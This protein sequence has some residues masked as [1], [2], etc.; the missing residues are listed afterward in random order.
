ML[1]VLVVLLQKIH[2]ESRAVEEAVLVVNLERV[3]RRHVQRTLVADLGGDEFGQFDRRMLGE[4]E[5]RCKIVHC[6]DGDDEN[7]R[8]RRGRGAFVLEQHLRQCLMHGAVAAGDDEYVRT[9]VAK[10]LGRTFERAECL[11]V[12]GPARSGEDR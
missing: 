4:S 11:R 6:A 3:E 2:G 9:V 5:G 1:G 8:D 12:V 7:L 10:L